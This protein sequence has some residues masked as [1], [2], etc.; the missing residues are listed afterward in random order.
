[1]IKTLLI[2]LLSGISGQELLT[3]LQNDQDAPAGRLIAQANK[4]ESMV[5]EHKNPDSFKS[6][7]ELANQNGFRVEQHQ[8]ETS[9]GYLLDLWRIPGELQD[10]GGEK[11][12]PVL[13]LHG[14]ESDMMQWVMNRPSHAPAF[15]LARNGYDVWMG[16][17]RGTRFG[18]K[19]ATLDPKSAE[20]WEF[21]WEEMGTKDVPAFV[22]HI[23]SETGFKQISYIG[24]S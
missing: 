19:H 13:L 7:T 12:P 3:N 1:M 16:N 10:S 14:V 23:V 8:V 2:V 18:L 17:N 15:T 22:D 21:S 24:H 4:F 6:M 20:F 9:D 5:D 11:K